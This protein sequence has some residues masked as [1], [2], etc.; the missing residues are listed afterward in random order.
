MIQFSIFGVPVRIAPWHWVG[1]AFISGALNMRSSEM[2]PF[3]LILAVVAFIS[4][5]T[6]ELGHALVGRALGGGGA[7]ITL[8]A[9]GGYCEQFGARFNKHTKAAMIAAGPGVNIFTMIICSFICLVVMDFSVSNAFGLLLNYLING[10]YVVFSFVSKGYIDAEQVKLYFLLGGFVWVSFWWSLLNLLP[11]FPMD[12]GQLL[13]QYVK[14][15][16]IVYMI[17]FVC[18]II[19]AIIGFYFFQSI[20]MLVFMGMFAVQNYQMMRASSYNRY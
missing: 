6:H 20:L 11:I 14:K 1:L 10:P 18:S 17:G 8:I 19:F 3:V 4:I 12:G 16:K 5:L 15:D 13:L 2:L 7:A 9:F